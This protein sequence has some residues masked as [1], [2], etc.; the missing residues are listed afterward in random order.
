MSK[1]A[2][3]AIGG[4]SLINAKEETTILKQWDT[5]RETCRHMVDIVA[6]GYDLVITHGNGPQVGYNLRRGE[7]AA[8]E[9]Y[10]LPLDIIVAHTQGSIGYMLQ[11]AMGNEMWSRDMRKP[12]VTLV[13]QVMVDR[14]DPGFKNPTK[15]IGGFLTEENARQFEK[16]GWV[17]VNDAGRGWRRV[18]A[19]P[20][21]LRIM[22]RGAIRRLL[23]NGSIVIAVGGGGIPV[24]RNEGGELR[25]LTGVFAVIDKDRASSLL[26]QRLKVDLFVI[27]TAVEQV[28]LNFNTPQQRA[29]AQMTVSEARQYIAEGHF[30]PGSMLP[31]VEA[32]VEYV[33]ATG[34]TGIIT[35][36]PNI[37][38][39][40]RGESGTRIVAD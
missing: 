20:K 22:E 38:R 10:Q 9:L 6:D 8:H 29:V 4:N 15:P 28:A 33:E 19:S 1:T 30:A 13:T 25:E 11:Q 7:L 16:D 12:V 24:V 36:P 35:D 2:L 39:A 37:T 34:H 40:L 17:V 21:P 5:V 31:K 23:K 18:V 27:S 14:D 3:V 32:M 26:A